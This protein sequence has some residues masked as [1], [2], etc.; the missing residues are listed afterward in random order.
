MDIEEVIKSE[1][2]F[3]D[4]LFGDHPDF[5]TVVDSKVIDTDRWHHQN[6]M[7]IKDLVTGKYYQINY[8][9]GATEYQEVPFDEM[10]ITYKQVEPYE[11]TV[12][13]YKEVSTQRDGGR[14]D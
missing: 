4:V 3:F 11:K 5:G 6:E 9:T 14:N 12:I 7:V 2:D 1:E 8:T 13:A 10:N